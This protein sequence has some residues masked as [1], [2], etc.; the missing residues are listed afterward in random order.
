MNVL[1]NTSTRLS[2][3]PDGQFW[4]PSESLSYSYWTRYLDVFNEVR[5]VARVMKVQEAP[6]GAKPVSGQYVNVLPLPNYI[7]ARQFARDYLSLRRLVGH[8]VSNAHAIQLAIPCA[9]GDLVW[10]SLQSGRPFGV[11]VCGDP[12]EVLARGNLNHPLRPVLRWWSRH[13]LLAECR[14]ACACAYVTRDVL[15]KRYPCS[16]GVFSTSYSSINLPDEVIIADPRNVKQSATFHLISVTTFETLYKGPDTLLEAISACRKRDLDVTL[17]FVGDGKHRR[18]VEELA[19]T[20]GL[21]NRVRFTGHLSSSAAVYAE[22]DAADLFVHPSRVDGLP[23]AV[24]EAMARAMPCIATAVGGIPELLSL[25]DLVPANDPATLARRIEEVLGN[26]ERMRKM[27]SRNLATAQH[28]RSD[29]L[30]VRRVAFY[31][32]LRSQTSEWLSTRQVPS[33]L[34]ANRS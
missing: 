17:T 33:R 22:L 4:A 27:S 32:I 29:V 6:R 9:I 10:R 30:R 31:S 12:Y 23:R 5:I 13:S 16:K 14:R 1:V 26:P 7:G 2:R 21:A 15:Q 18:E 19:G 24:V 8:Y 3:T 28:Y 25:E 11:V 34:A 20:L